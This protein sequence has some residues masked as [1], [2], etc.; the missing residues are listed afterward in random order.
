MT[1]LRELCGIYSDLFKSVNG[2]RPSLSGLTEAEL[3]SRIAALSER[4]AQQIEAQK[5]EQEASIS[6]FEGIVKEVVKT[7][8]QDRATAIR[9]LMAAEGCSDTPSGRDE[10]E[11]NNKLPCGYLRGN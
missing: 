11:F 5:S 9:W 4:S 8:A 2:I 3:E 6:I 7:G 1:R 10:F